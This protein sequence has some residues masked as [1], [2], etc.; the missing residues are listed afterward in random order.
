M[1]PADTG[2]EDHQ[3]NWI[4]W[5]SFLL[6]AYTYLGYALWLWLYQQWCFRPVD[7]RAITPSVSIVIAAHNEAA[8]LPRKL[9]NLSQLEYPQE[10]LEII[11]VSDGSTDDTDQILKSASTPNF[12]SLSLSQHSGK[13]A[14]LNRGIATAKGDVIVFMDARQEI[15]PDAVAKLVRNFADPTVGC[16]SGELMLKKVTSSAGQEG[17]GLY[18][19]IE[20]AIRKMESNTGSVVGATGALYAARRELLAP[21]PEGA[22]TSNAG[23]WNIRPLLDDVFLPLSVAAQGKRIVFEPEARAWDEMPRDAMKEFRRKVRT[24]TGNY[25]LIW[26]APW[27]LTRANPLRFRF[28]SHKLSRLVAPLALAALLLSSIWLDGAVYRA[29]LIFQTCFYASS[30]GALFQKPFGIVTKLG[31]ATSAFLLLN[32]AAVLAFFNFI[33]RKRPVWFCA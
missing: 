27:L 25:Q 29:A 31:K 23:D 22:L 14:A 6:L 1:V 13:V 11:V 10:L 28:I 21:M 12:L 32:A 5:I 33:A 26:L 2:T 8:V 18:W 3:V 19:R 16:V 24:S 20:K 4:F 7:K 17:L 30:A 9:N 15:E